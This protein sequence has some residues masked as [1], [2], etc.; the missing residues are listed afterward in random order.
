MHKTAIGVAIFFSMIFLY[1]SFFV[2]ALRI[3]M[4]DNHVYRR[5]KDNR[6]RSDPW[7]SIMMGH[8]LCLGHGTTPSVSGIQRRRTVC[9][10][11]KDIR[12]RSDLQ[13]REH[14]PC[15]KHDSR[16]SNSILLNSSPNP[17]LTGAIIHGAAFQC[18]STH[19]FN[20]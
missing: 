15:A 19:R 10:R 13:S 18:K 7:R 11:W 9:R 5:W 8:V 14:R 12:V 17:V 4:A 16:S 2:L 6:M 20:G 3:P 1:F